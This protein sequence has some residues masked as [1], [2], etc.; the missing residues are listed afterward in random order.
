[1][2]VLVCSVRSNS[3]QGRAPEKWQSFPGR[4]GAG[5]PH[6]FILLCL[7]ATLFLSVAPCRAQVVT[8]TIVGTVRD[9]SSK[10]LPGATVTAEIAARGIKRAVV[11]NERGEYTFTLLPVGEYRVS[12]ELPGF[13]PFIRSGVKVS[14]D[15]RLRLDF[16]LRVGGP[17]EEIVVTG[18]TPLVKSESSNVSEV[19]S[20][21]RVAGLPLNGR[22]FIDLVTL[23][24]GATPEVQ[25]KFGSQFG[26]AGLSSNVNGNRGD[27]NNF[28][29]DGVPINDTMWGRMATAPSVDAIQEMQ[30]QSFLYSAEY[31]NQG[32]AQ[33]NLTLRSGSNEFHGVGFLFLRRDAFDARN[34]FADEKPPLDENQFG[35]SI[36]G[37]I[38]KDRSFFFFNYEGQRVDRGLTLIGTVP[39]TAMR[40]GDFSGG[41]TLFNPFD[42]DPSSG[43][44]RVFDGNQIPAGLIN[45]VA[46]EVLALVPEPNRPG[47]SRNFVGTD[48]QNRKMDQYNVRIDNQLSD[49][50]SLFGHFNYADL[51]NTDPGGGAVT[52]GGQVGAL[53]GFAPTVKLQTATLG[54]NWTRTLS[55]SLINQAR[56]G[57]T[58]IKT[59]ILT[60]RPDLN[61]AQQV[62]IQGTSD[63]P[64]TF[65]IPLFQ[66]AGLTTVG[67]TVSSLNGINNDF[68]YIDDLSWNVG[69]HAL[70]F[71]VALTRHQINPN[72]LVTP[73]GNFVFNSIFTSGG[74]GTGSA[75]ADFLLGL[76]QQATA[77][78]GDPQ[79]YGR[80][81]RQAYYVQ[82]DWKI[83]SNFTLNLGIRY[84][85]LSP[86]IDRYNRFANI[87]LMG[88]SGDFVIACDNGA[89]NPKA[90]FA[91][92]PQLS[93]VCSDA[94]GLPRGLTRK[95]R[96]DWAPRIGFAW[97]VWGDKLVIRSGYGIFYSYPNMAV[98]TGTPSFNP[99]FFSIGVARNS[100][101]DPVPIQ[102]LLVAPGLNNPIGQPFSFNYV[103]GYVQ[104]WTLNLQSQVGPSTLLE[105]T[106]LGS[107]GTKLNAEIQP[108][109]V[110]PE[111]G[112]NR[113]GFFGASAFFAGP[114]A[115]STYESLQLRVNQRL[116]H[117]ISF[118]T[119]YT[120]S[121]SLD[122]SGGTLS[123]SANSQVPQNSFNLAAEYGRS[124]WDARHRFVFNGLFDLPFGIGKPF[125]GGVSTM[126]D[127]II[128]HWQISVAATLM[129]GQ[130]LTPQLAQDRAGSH[131]FQD[132]PNL[133]G[134]PNN[135]SHQTPDQFFN[136]DA[137]ALQPAGQFGNAGRNIIDGPGF[138]S[139]D[140]AVLKNVPIEGE[141]RFQ[142]RAEFFNLFNRVNFNLPNRIFDSSNFGKIFSARDPR[143][144]QFAFKYFF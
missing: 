63:N 8:G 75:F 62:G 61:F 144:I 36:G 48:T 112:T 60:G 96:N 128:G 95:D 127:R 74:E 133:V 110:N 12:A 107:K 27:A 140:L 105:A 141:H 19:L 78:V 58:R 102:T 71:G 57:F 139:V 69:N 56:F 97:S 29:L 77:G 5:C 124:F 117:G 84:E 129:S 2:K 137:F 80:A 50:D 47:E 55:A 89:F 35:G 7:L 53:P 43:E 101:T 115:W 59:R 135:I 51:S 66:I 82:D 41:P 11:T 64:Q 68:N 134:D 28:M 114:F 123:N 1:M 18:E 76:P 31:G 126:A 37:P 4:L 65:G 79:L 125:G 16:T 22:R 25:G 131:T 32:G 106:Y 81:W 9:T 34:F 98:R 38:L 54:L 73:R 3:P 90:D 70:K 130:P 14:A 109:M 30:I 116:W 20:E 33:V 113:F 42:V 100:L 21:V 143:Q 17:Q 94:V 104:Q 87:D 23:T 72:F 26:L 111:T 138:S 67:D 132:R 6:F 92:F 39:T 136:T 45:P 15:A 52:G 85:Y 49:N 88:Q 86:P 99:P 108:N 46:K 118:V 142:F 24:P 44:K 93:F 83:T 119:H 10:V 121:K 122:T 40:N 91:K 103:T 120:F 13:S